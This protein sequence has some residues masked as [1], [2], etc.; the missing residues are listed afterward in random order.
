MLNLGFS[1][2]ASETLAG[3]LNLHIRETKSP[4]VVVTSGFAKNTVRNT[5]AVQKV[6]S[7][8]IA[9]VTPTTDGFFPDGPDATVERTGP[10]AT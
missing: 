5:R 7:H 2:R 3:F 6:S 4:G 8:I 1:F 10:G 9:L